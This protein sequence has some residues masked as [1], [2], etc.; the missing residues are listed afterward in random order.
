MLAL[1]EEARDA[2]RAEGSPMGPLTFAAPETLCTY[3]PPALLSTFRFRYP[4]V[5]LPFRAI[6]SADT[7]T[8]VS[9]GT[10]PMSWPCTM[11]AQV[12]S[13]GARSL[14]GFLSQRMRKDRHLESRAGHDTPC[15]CWCKGRTG[16][17]RGQQVN[18]VSDDRNGP[19][20]PPDP[21]P[22]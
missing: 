7:R 2:V 22:P 20:G 16:E 17:R 11:S 21:A 1:A 18:V 14:L 3:R 5:R 13:S 6:G 19:V 10:A 15:G 8:A 9:E 12:S 4:G